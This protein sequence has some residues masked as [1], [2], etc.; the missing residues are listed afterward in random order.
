MTL[1]T[2]AGVA[3]AR[4]GRTL[5]DGID[6][7]LGPGDAMLV[8]GPNGAGKTTLLRIAAGLLTPAAGRVKR[9]ARTAWLG[10]AAALDGERTLDDALLFWARADGLDDPRARVTHGLAVLGLT[11]LAAV[12]V[13]FLSTGQRRRAALARMVAAAAPLWL[14][15]EPL[16][17]LDAA[18]C[19]ALEQV[20][21]AHRTN[22]GAVLAASHQSLSLPAAGRVELA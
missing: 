1:L 19:A 15:D 21:A 12:P 22:G 14:L 18:A 7:A 13:R 16:N 20:I 17:G 2:L 9:T 5:F 11:P 8:T 6:L 10:E 3:G 4:G